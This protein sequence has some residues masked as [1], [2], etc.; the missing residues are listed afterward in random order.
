LDEVLLVDKNNNIIKAIDSNVFFVK[1]GTIVIPVDFIN[2]YQKIFTQFVIDAA[3]K[4][5]I[6]IV[7][8]EI[9]DS[10]LVS[11]DEIFLVNPVFGLK[12]ILAYKEKRYYNKISSQLVKSINK[13]LLNIPTD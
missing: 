9:K 11:F 3:I 2:N 7:S 10:D 13:L 6:K 4:Q 1:N 12:W 5:N 8:A